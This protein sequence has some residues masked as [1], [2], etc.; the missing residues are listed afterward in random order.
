MC[1]GG[2]G[3]SNL[4]NDIFLTKIISFL[5]VKKCFWVKNIHCIQIIQ[6]RSE[7]DIRCKLLESDP[8]PGEQ[9]LA[10]HQPSKSPLK[11]ILSS[12]SVELN[13]VQV[14][15]EVASE[16]CE[17]ATPNFVNCEWFIPVAAALSMIVSPYRKLL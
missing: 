11:L 12:S 3:N 15:I 8:V 5:P 13:Q 14:G 16:V 1:F 6:N 4:G 7:K 2:G 9:T 10:R 17:L